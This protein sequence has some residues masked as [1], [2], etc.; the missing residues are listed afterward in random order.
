[1]EFKNFGDAVAKQFA[2]MAKMG[3]LFTVEMN[4]TEGDDGERVHPLWETYLGAFPEGSN[5]IYRERTEHDCNCCKN[6]I[7]T[8]GNVV[9]LKDGK[10]VTIWDVT[11]PGEP[12]YQVVANAMAAKVRSA[13]ISGVFYHYE[14]TVGRAKTFE[15]LTGKDVHTWNHF[16]VNLPREV[17]LRKD[18][19]ATIKGQKRA[20]YDVLNRS[21]KEL[22]LESVD[23]VLELIAQNSLYRGAEHKGAVEEFR[24]LKKAYDKSTEKETFAWSASQGTFASVIRFR[25]TVIGTLVSDL[26]SGVDLEAAVKMFESK[27]A[28]ANYKRPSALVTQKMVDDAKKKVAELGLTSALERRYAN[29]TDISI[30]NVLFANRAT[31]KVIEGDAFSDIA[32]KTGVKSKSL[33]KVEEVGIEKFLADILP[34]AEKIELLVENQHQ[35]N[36]VSL[37]AP[38][39]PTAGQLFK[40]SNGFSWAY[41]GDMA[42]A[43]KERVKAAGGNVTG[44]FCCRLA[45]Y[46][47]DDLDF[48]MIEHG[49]KNKATNR[50][51]GS[52][53]IY[54]GNK[55]SKSPNGG[56]LD[57][58]MN[59]G[60]GTT[61]TPVE[62]IV[63]ENISNMKPG[64]YTLSVT[65]YSKRDSADQGFDVQID[66]LGT[67]YQVHFEK[68]HS[69]GVNK[70]IAEF[71][72]TDD[73]KLVLLT[74]LKGVTQ[75]KEIWGIKTNDFV[76]VNSIML[77]PNYWDG[78]LGI[79]NK[80]YFFMLDDCVND[81][82]ARG[83]F[84]EY[85]KAELDQHRK[86]LEIVGSKMTTAETPNQLSGLGF[87]STNR[88]SVT[89][90]VSGSFSRVLKIVF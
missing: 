57:V 76:N 51:S 87:S 35:M 58:D 78:Q 72:K 66:I 68:N 49:S 42:D 75:S 50:T 79:G 47:Y 2:V 23:I 70:V 43:I 44:D 8:I 56:M 11:I 6:F 36:L 84:N 27:V 15:Q 25:N 53:E 65:N 60:G 1:M 26:A 39:D 48:H 31:R 24:K 10:Y 14:S 5:P 22:D 67:V 33:D 3:T 17:V 62:N 81:G 55:R 9:A 12:E 88:A 52:H 28:P 41:N 71:E 73:G 45:W 69:S 82:K 21:L 61:R 74:D 20:D 63:Y 86:V 30:N 85:L 83:F 46:N 54:F 34:K 29:L 40:W 32:T 59:A 38:V 19:I 64:K 80:H 89:V 13:K 90:R 7:R 18:T 77:S 16:A 4:R 37:V